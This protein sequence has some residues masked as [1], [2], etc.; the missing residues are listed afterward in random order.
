MAIVESG[1]TTDQI[2]SDADASAWVVKEGTKEYIKVDTSNE[3]VTF[4]TGGTD[5]VF[6]D[7]SGDLQLVG[8][9]SKLEFITSTSDDTPIAQLFYDSGQNQLY[10]NAKEAASEVVVKTA[11]TTRLTV[12]ATGQL[13][14]GTIST[15]SGVTNVAIGDA[16]TLSSVAHT[17]VAHNVAIGS[18]ALELLAGDENLSHSIDNI[19]IGR[20]AMDSAT[21]AY[22]NVAIGK[23]SGGG[24]TTGS[25]NI[26]LGRKAGFSTDTGSQNICIGEDA[27]Y[28]IGSSTHNNTIVG[29]TESGKLLTSAQC[30]LLGANIAPAMTVGTGTIAIGYQAAANVTAG[31]ANSNTSLGAYN[32]YIGALTRTSAASTGVTNEVAIGYNSS[33]MGSNTLHLGANTI[34]RSYL[35]RRIDIWNPTEEDTA[36]GREGSIHF[37]GE[38]SGGELH[39]MAKI[40]GVHKGTGDD[41][42]GVIQFA[43]NSGSVGETLSGGSVRMSITDHGAAIGGSAAAQ[44]ADHGSYPLLV[45]GSALVQD[46]DAA[47]RTNSADAVAKNFLF[48]KSR[49]ATDGAHTVVANDDVLG[50]IE[51]RGSDGDSFAPAAK[52][53]ARVDGTPGD[54]D[55]PTELVFAVS[56]VGSESPTERLNI[57]PSGKV[58][59]NPA[60][61][62]SLSALI[63]QPTDG[64]GCIYATTS[65]TTATRSIVDFKGNS[66]GTE[67]LSVYATGRVMMAN[68]PT[69]NPGIAGHIYRDGSGDAATIKFS[70]G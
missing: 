36:L 13:I 40:S 28:S 63:I 70:T 18:G 65:S 6:I 15:Y 44:A 34:T 30:V 21:T 17:A 29:G 43:C 58:V 20:D 22:G 25:N 61:G 31:S 57:L 69:S 37:L 52:I 8:G 47:V 35:S 23:N 50:T 48:E 12:S 24:I 49:N 64:A 56:A 51:W 32:M 19:A 62:S 68:L 60:V 26:F 3:K 55:M 9:A 42:S 11:D 16:T 46:G 27:G 59:L 45:N 33:G 66:G 14:T 53:F 2:L 1:Q 39:A 38:K 10:I 67:V 41:E 4:G 7:T 54:G 5:R